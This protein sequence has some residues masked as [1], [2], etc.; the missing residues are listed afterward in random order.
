MKDITNTRTM[1]DITNTRTMKDITNTGTMNDIP[2]IAS[3]L[4]N[5]TVNVINILSNK[6]H[7]YFK[8]KNYLLFMMSNI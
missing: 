3:T 8:S 7:V 1:K 2:E 5:N 4:S 6:Y